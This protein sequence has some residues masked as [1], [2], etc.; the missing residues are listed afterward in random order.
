MASHAP[1]VTPNAQL[2]EPPAVSFTAVTPNGTAWNNSNWFQIIAST[3]AAWVLTGLTVSPAVSN[4]DYEFDIGV[5][6]AGNEVVIAT[7]G[8]FVSAGGN[9]GCAWQFTPTSVPIDAIPASSRV[10]VRMRKVGT[11]TAQ[12]FVD[13]HYF[14]K[15]GLGVGT[16]ANP[17]LVAPAAAAGVAVATNTT[18]GANSSWVELHSGLTN[19]AILSVVC[20]FP[21]VADYWEIDI[22]YGTA[23]N[24]V[25]AGT[26]ALTERSNIGNRRVFPFCIPIAIAGT[27]RI[28]IRVR[29]STSA[30]SI[31]PTFRLI[32]VSTSDFGGSLPEWTTAIPA[33]TSSA[34]ALPTVAGAAVNHA[35]SNYVELITSTSTA[36]VLTGITVDPAVASVGYEV[37]IAVGGAGSEVVICTIVDV[38]LTLGGI[39]NTVTLDIPIDAIPASSR[40]SARFRKDGT[41][42][43]AWGFGIQYVPKPL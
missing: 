24:E 22:G 31:S 3:G 39:D 32:Y 23:G 42:T 28:A 13:M 40:V 14:L 36:I 29:R 20:N 41:S 35:N 5:G 18:G 30:A 16:T 27:N 25:V 43:S 37:D 8:G 26:I 15:T 6:S 33:I 1:G 2:N 7:L 38:S 11:S 19:I 4:V 17:T 34:A 21:S 10:S 12:W 9:S